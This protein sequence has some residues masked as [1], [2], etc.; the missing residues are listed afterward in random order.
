MELS[1]IRTAG[2]VISLGI[3]FVMGIYLVARRKYDRNGAQLEKTKIELGEV[4]TQVQNQEIRIRTLEESNKRVNQSLDELLRGMGKIDG[5]M[6]G[7][8]NSFR[9]IEEH[10][11]NKKG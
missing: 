3:S 2:S 7:L 9:I 5:Q 6:V 8:N 1:D 4:K 10:L 11:I